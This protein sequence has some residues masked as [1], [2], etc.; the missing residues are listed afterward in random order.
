VKK[1]KREGRL[2][3]GKG[4]PSEERGHWR[5][6]CLGRKLMGERQ[7]LNKKIGERG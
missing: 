6:G 3:C 2:S 5:K 1:A 7:H 4:G